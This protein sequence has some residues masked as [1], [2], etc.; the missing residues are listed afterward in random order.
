MYT[1]L[2]KTLNFCFA[3]TQD[4]KTLENSV[5]PHHLLFQTPPKVYKF[6]LVM[7]SRLFTLLF[8]KDVCSNN[9]NATFLANKI[10][11]DELQ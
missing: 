2:Y 10:D 11:A 7:K 1:R 5:P 6:H 3:K 4:L 8:L 9:S